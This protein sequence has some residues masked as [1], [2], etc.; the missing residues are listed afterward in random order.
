MV[1]YSYELT[2]TDNKYF[3]TIEKDEDAI[4]LGLQVISSIL[5]RFPYLSLISRKGE[6]KLLENLLWL[7]CR[8]YLYS[9]YKEV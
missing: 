7:I 2:K 4:D 3:A 9:L 6:I 8:S 1:S 5:C